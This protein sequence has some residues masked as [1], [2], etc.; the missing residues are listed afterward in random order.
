M[1]NHDSWTLDSIV[2]A[3]KHDQRRVRGLREP[4]LKS[5]EAVFR[6]FLRFSLGEDPLDP[7]HL[8]PTDVVQF[9]T[10]LQDR[11]APGSMKQVR[12]ALRSLFRFLRMKGYCDEKL[13]LAI[14][15]V[16]HW[17]TATLPRCLDEQQLSQ[18][19]EAFDPQTPYGLRDRAMVLCLSTLGLRPRELAELRLED[20]DWRSG[21]L[22]LRTRKTRRG[23]VLPLPRQAGQAVVTYLRMGRPTTTERRVFVQHSGRRCGTA[24]SASAI[25]AAAVRAFR[26]AGVDAP[27]GGAY[28]FRH[29]VASRLV[30]R[31]APLKEVADF[32]GHQCLDTTTIYAKLDLPALREVALPWP[33]VLP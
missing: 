15:V 21:T 5:Y 1:I 32:L 4:T 24:L 9:I 3:Y 25:T 13:E 23:A 12:T 16:A 8:T 2:E 26:R 11:Y 18:V 10:S 30:A 19:M 14:P 29:T 28:V 6:P 31:G 17:R 33:E 22:R 27:P 7:T 20:I